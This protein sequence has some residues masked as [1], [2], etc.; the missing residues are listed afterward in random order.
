[1]SPSVYSLF[2]SVFFCSLVF[3]LNPKDPDLGDDHGAGAT[4]I[5]PAYS[6]LLREFPTLNEPDNNPT[7]DA[8]AE[9]GRLLFYDP[10]LSEN[11]DTSCASC[12][13]PDLGFADGLTKAVGPTG[14]ELARNTPTL[15]NVGYAENL[16]WDGRLD[17]LEAQAAF[18]L[19]H[20]DEMGVTDTDA[21]VAELVQLFPNMQMALLTPLVIQT[22]I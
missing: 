8:K 10:V 21:L 5:D 20:P 9:L 7:T 12:H 15:W 22:W 1:M 4:S 3:H 6:G 19:T 13:H 14:D 11:N 17:S 2:C 16:F 18:P